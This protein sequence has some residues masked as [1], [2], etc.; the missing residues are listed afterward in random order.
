MRQYILRLGSPLIACMLIVSAGVWAGCDSF[1]EPDPASFSTTANFYES[2]AQFEAAINGAYGRFRTAVGNTDYRYMADLRGPNLTRHFDVNLPHTVAGTPQLDEWTMTLNNGEVN[3]VW[4][5]MF[6]LIKETNVILTQIEDIE[7]SDN[8]LKERYKGEV[9]T[10][11]AFAYWA[12]A[13]FWG[14]VPIIL[15]QIRTPAD[16]VPEAGRQSVSTVYAQVVSDLQSAIGSLPATYSGNDVGRITSGAAQFLLGRTYMLTG[17]WQSAL[18]IFQGLDTGGNYMLLAN[19]RDVFD[20]AN[21]NNME[22]ILELQFDP[23]ITGQ[24]SMP[25]LIE[26]IVP[27]NSDTDLI[28]AIGTGNPAG[29]YLP[30][31]DVIDSYEAGD[32]RQDASIAWYVKPGNGDFVELARGDSLPILNKFYFPEHIS[33][34][35]Y[36]TNWIVFRFADVLL[37]AAEASWQLGQDGTAMGYLDRVRSRAGLP[38]VDLA[39]YS[40]AITGSPLGD[41]IL[42]ERSIELLGEAHNWLDLLRFGDD[43]AMS[44]M[45]DH[46]EK[47]R[48]RDSKTLDVYVIQSFKLLYPVPV[49]DTDLAG[50]SQN[51]GW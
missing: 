2:E 16:A 1:L 10:M 12:A 43:V 18:T 5:N 48:A 25:A 38:S 9:L 51:P 15:D 41:A 31:P 30:T 29:R 37:S 26:D 33:T 45:E 27:F 14:D 34:Q 44:V 13:Q 28:P 19:Y 49:R 7:F 3:G 17:D 11:R 20:P 8:T 36:N 23:N 46:G 39:N 22:S 35:G 6:R 50:L 40:G 42:H 21:K 47:F 4:T 32:L 24:G